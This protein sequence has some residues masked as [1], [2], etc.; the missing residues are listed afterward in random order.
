MTYG[1]LTYTKI[2][3]RWIRD[4]ITSTFTY[5]KVTGRWTIHIGSFWLLAEQR[6]HIS[7]EWMNDKTWY[8]TE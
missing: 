2:K 6:W 1:R 8:F 4:L 5:L 7:G 3:G